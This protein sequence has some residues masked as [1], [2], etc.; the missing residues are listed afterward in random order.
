VSDPQPDD[1]WPDE[2]WPDDWEPP[3]PDEQDQRSWAH[4][5]AEEAW[6]AL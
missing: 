1:Y 2:V 3:G 6:D 4:E 5:V